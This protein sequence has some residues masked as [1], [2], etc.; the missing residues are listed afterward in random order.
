MPFNRFT[1]QQLTNQINVLSRLSERCID[2][3]MSDPQLRDAATL[4]GSRIRTEID[5]I[6]RHRKIK[7]VAKEAT[8]YENR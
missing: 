3:Q 7:H 5:R 6:N 1:Y 4:I 2:L 8:K